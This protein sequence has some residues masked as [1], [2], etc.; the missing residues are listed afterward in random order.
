[1]RIVQSAN[2][3]ISMIL[4]ISTKVL[5]YFYFVC[6][7]VINYIICRCKRLCK[8]WELENYLINVVGF[9]FNTLYIYIYM[10]R[11]T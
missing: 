10:E 5:K 7:Q 1:M 4:C 3:P 11:E 8:A 2:L 6:E 9:Y